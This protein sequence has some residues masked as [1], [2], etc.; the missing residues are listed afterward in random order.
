[1]VGDTVKRV[2][3]TFV[4]AFLGTMAFITYAY[5]TTENYP[6][7]RGLPVA[8]SLGGA[9]AGFAILKNLLVKGRAR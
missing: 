6:W 7:I 2:F 1:M 9:A 4:E 3:W 5:F 8:A